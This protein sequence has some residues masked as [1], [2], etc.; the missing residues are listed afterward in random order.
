MAADFSHLK[1]SFGLDRIVSYVF[2]DIGG[3]PALQVRFAGESNS[4]LFNER[5][6][7]HG[8]VLQNFNKGK[9]V[10]EHI[11]R[12]RRDD[13][14]LYAKYVVTGWHD[15]TDANGAV[16]EFSEENVRE[17]LMAI[18]S[19]MFDEFRA[20]CQDPINF[21]DVEGMGELGKN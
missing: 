16:V 2:S 1:R 18:P 11:D 15:V 12:I 13:I 21:S 4:A 14:A 5:M 19:F 8:R 20:F 9:I 10:A 6:K 3:S 17:F 7:K